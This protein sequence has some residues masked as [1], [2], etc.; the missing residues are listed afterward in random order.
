MVILNEKQLS[1][2]WRKTLKI[3]KP[4]TENSD[5]RASTNVTARGAVRSNR[6]HCE[7]QSGKAQ[8]LAGQCISALATA[9]LCAR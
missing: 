1:M 9:G 2:L 4:V 5:V 3:V 8:S 6:W 7:T